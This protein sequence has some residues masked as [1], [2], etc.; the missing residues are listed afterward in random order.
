MDLLGRVQQRCLVQLGRL[1]GG[2]CLLGGIRNRV[3]VLSPLELSLGHRLLLRRDLEWWRL[4]TCLSPGPDLRHRFALRCGLRS[5]FSA[6]GL[7]GP[8]L[9]VGEYGDVGWGL[10]LGPGRLHGPP[11]RP[12]L[13]RYGALG[14][15]RFPDPYGRVV[16]GRR[17]RSVD[18]GGDQG[19]LRLAGGLIMPVTAAPLTGSCISTTRFRRGR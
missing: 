10:A 11:G 8:V 18:L 9:G 12:Q 17:S 3:L 4:R 6:C 7:R 16:P 1:P 14:A 19:P 5:L 15:G 13:L 2:L